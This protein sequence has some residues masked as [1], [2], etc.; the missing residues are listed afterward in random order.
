MTQIDLHTVPLVSK[1]VAKRVYSKWAAE[2]GNPYRLRGVRGGCEYIYF[3]AP[4]SE[5]LVKIGWSRDP[6]A[7]G[8]TLRNLDG[9]AMYP[10]VALI[11]F[12]F[13][14]ENQLHRAL[15]HF[16]IARY[17][18]QS[19]FEFYRASSPIFDLMRRM[20]RSADASL[21]RRYKAPKP[22]PSMIADRQRFLCNNQRAAYGWPTVEGSR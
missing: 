14:D 21:A 12:G 10:R 3:A 5:N 2:I 4:E 17:P 13:F 16:A 15:N 18:H 19:D 9:L 11:G 8:K 6:V 22:R 20:I 1:R 7:R